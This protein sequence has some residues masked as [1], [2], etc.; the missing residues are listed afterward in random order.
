MLSRST[1]ETE[2]FGEALAKLL[3]PGDT[4]WLYGGLGAGKTAFTRGIAR[5]LGVT[6]PV[7]SPTYAIA[8][9]YSGRLSLF[10]F[11][12]YRLSG[13]DDL[14]GAGWDDQTDG[15]HVVEWAERAG[16][17]VSGICVLLS[18]SG[19]GEREIDVCC[20]P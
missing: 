1:E 11:D 5:G 8:N 2:G 19:D 13:L 20:L 15:V 18:G 6:E 7:L 12:A 14:R 17:S 9:E 4:V 3:R 10:H 16:N